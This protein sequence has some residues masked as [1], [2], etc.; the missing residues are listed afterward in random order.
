M[1]TRRYFL[2]AAGR[3]CCLWRSRI[4]CRADLDL[5]FPFRRI[6]AAT[7]PEPLREGLTRA[8]ILDSIVSI[9][10]LSSSREPVS[11]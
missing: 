7:W 11:S 6:P 8:I 4:A 9:E 3:A 2:Q 5:V 10:F 1:R